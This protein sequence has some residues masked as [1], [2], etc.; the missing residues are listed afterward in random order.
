MSKSVILI[1]GFLAFVFLII[2]IVLSMTIVNRLNEAGEKADL[3]W[4][5][6][7]A[8]GYARKYKEIKIKESGRPDMLYY[9]FVTSSF[10][11]FITLSIGIVLVYIK[12]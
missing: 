8:F 10:L 3:K 7:K 5:R 6:F 12:N 11:F 1:P 4:L 2:N 9:L